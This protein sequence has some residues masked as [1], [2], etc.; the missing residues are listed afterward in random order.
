MLVH[1]KSCNHPTPLTW[2]LKAYALIEKFHCVFKHCSMIVF[3]ILCYWSRVLPWL[4]HGNKWTLFFCLFVCP[5]LGD[6][7]ICVIHFVF[8]MIYNNPCK[9]SNLQSF[10]RIHHGRSIYLEIVF[11][12]KCNNVFS[13]MHWI[14]S[15]SLLVISDRPW[16]WDAKM[17][18]A[19]SYNGHACVDF[20]CTHP[21]D[22]LFWNLPIYLL[23][24]F[25][26]YECWVT[27]LVMP[28]YHFFWV[29]ICLFVSQGFISLWNIK[30]I[31]WLIFKWN[32][33][34]KHRNN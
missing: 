28:L 25:S 16:L 19:L 23:G 12:I 32:L 6:S 24:F 21:I 4:V 5:L 30:K 18:I 14:V 34:D 27:N 20:G 15:S 1:P 26:K 22:G 7:L 13:I 2:F 11:K 33:F 31:H 9:G 29:V 8:F 17:I 10:W 3:N